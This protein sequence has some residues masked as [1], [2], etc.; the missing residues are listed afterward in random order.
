MYH[1]LLHI[2]IYSCNH[3]LNT[4]LYIYLFIMA[5]DAF[6]HVLNKY[7]SKKKNKSKSYD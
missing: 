2:Y 4:H 3:V 7:M 5:L 6:N 1:C